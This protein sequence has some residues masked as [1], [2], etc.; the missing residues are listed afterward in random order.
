MGLYLLCYSVYDGLQMCSWD[1][2]EDTRVHYPQVLRTYT[3]RGV[4]MAVLSQEME[5]S[6]GLGQP[7]GVSSPR[8]MSLSQFGED[9]EES[10][11][12]HTPNP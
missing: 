1:Y 8:N 9:K 7:K 6:N 4:S 10:T 2:R 3:H 12:R 11:A 5:S